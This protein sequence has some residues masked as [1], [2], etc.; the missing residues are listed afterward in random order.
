MYPIK[1]LSAMVLTCLLAV[2]FWGCALPRQGELPATVCPNANVQAEITPFKHAYQITGVCIIGEE[3]ASFDISA[4]W[5]KKG[6]E[7]TS[8]AILKVN[9]QGQNYQANISGNCPQDPL[10]YGG[11]CSNRAIQGSLLATVL[12]VYY[13]QVFQTHLMPD[14]LSEAQ[15]AE[16]RAK[17]QWPQAPPI[18]LVPSPGVPPDL[19]YQNPDFVPIGYKLPFTAGKPSDWKLTFGYQKWNI[20]SG[21]W[22]SPVYKTMTEFFLSSGGTHSSTMLL[23]L[24]PGKYKLSWV[25]YEYND[26]YGN[27]WESG[28]FEVPVEFRVGQLKIAREDL[29][30]EWAKT[31]EGLDRSGAAPLAGAA[32][33]AGATV[34]AKVTPA[35]SLPAGPPALRLQNTS[36][37]APA[38]VQPLVQADG[39]FKVNFVLEKR[40][41]GGF[42]KIAEAGEPR[43][44]VADPGE[45]RIR[46]RYEGGTAETL[47]PFT[48][49]P[50]TLPAPLPTPAPSGRMPLK[51]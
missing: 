45:Y 36:F 10:L 42:R 14:L 50:K 24:A 6:N 13:A 12:W 33:K 44:Q 5:N 39:K 47:L 37:T 48:V 29:K 4:V 9:Y 46:A 19:H 38:L 35:L 23:S 7:T 20:G 1:G 2:T 25:K 3:A 27:H 28:S 41:N 34:A 43:F 17:D 49:K 15:K 18:V 51:K 8:G 26:S 11:N 40:E 21:N 16:L 32:P 22:E 30:M 31:L